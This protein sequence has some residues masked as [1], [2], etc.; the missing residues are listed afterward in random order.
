M[1]GSLKRLG[2]DY[3]DLYYQYRVDPK[4]RIEETVEAMAELAKEGKYR[5]LGL[6]E[7]SAK[8][9]HRTHKVHPIAACQL[10]YSL[11]YQDIEM[12]D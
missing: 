11:F 10:E 3:I 7:C 6:S 12:L 1:E 9:L 4:T 5:Y 8:T 2:T